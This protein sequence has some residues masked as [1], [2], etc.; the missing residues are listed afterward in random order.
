[1]SKSRASWGRD[2]DPDRLALL[3]LRM[4]KAYYRR[5][6]ARLF[7]LL[8]RANREQAAASWPRAVLAAV[9][10]A[11]GAVAFGRTGWGGAGDVVARD[12]AAYLRD[13]VRGYRMLGLPVGVDVE[14]V[15]RRELRW[16]TVRREIGVAA[17]EAAGD[18]IAALYAELYGL[19]PA[20]VAEAGRLRGRA[21]EVRDRGAIADPDGPAGRG[22]S[23]WPEVG[24]LLVASYR[25]LKTAIAPELAP[26][27]ALRP[28]GDAQP[29]TVSAD[30]EVSH[31]SA[32]GAS[33]ARRAANEY[34]FL[35]TWLIP[36]TADDIVAVLGDAESLA[37]WWPSVYLG[38]EVLEPGDERGLGRVVDLYT[39]GWLPYT[40]RWQFR[41]TQ[42]D[43][44]HGFTIE[45]SGDF[46][47]RGIWTLTPEADVDAGPRTR[48]DYDWRILA[49]KGLLKRLSFL[50]KPIFAANHRWAMAQG[51]KSL[52]LELARRRAAG[53]AAATAAAI[54]A[55]PGAD[56]LVPDPPARAAGSGRQRPGLREVG[57]GS[58]RPDRVRG[59]G[60]AS[61]ATSRCTSS[62]EG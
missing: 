12:D 49:E 23:Y 51:E 26:E 20:V 31:G 8:V 45:A 43:P 54:P 34:A 7:G 56:F 35:T 13:I 50:M 42:S 57:R 6:P 48:V 55:P 39:K 28:G 15:A 11:R 29:G 17:G 58:R 46:V 36:A 16:W 22:A 10:L 52:R 37:C 14:E 40:L 1:M 5:Q 9:Y 62:A 30:P 4:W 3:E 27:A 53:E 59:A 32:G 38:V 44:P 61:S 47:G 19:P 60:P 18:A 2:F 41:V 25:A 24:R 21:A 33:G